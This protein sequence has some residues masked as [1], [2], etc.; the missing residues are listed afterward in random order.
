MTELLV[1]TFVKNHKDVENS[2]VRTSYGILASIVGIICNLILFG[3]KITVG[4]IMNSI[5]VMADA[6]NNLSDAA[7]SIISF[8]GVKLAERP[9]DKEHPFGHGRFEYIAALAVSFLILQ[10]GFSLFQSSFSKVLHPEDIKFNIVSVVILCVSVVI[11]IWLMFF[12]RKLGKRIKSSV[13]LATAADSLGDVTVTTATIISA[14]IAGITGLKIDGYVGLIVSIFV[15]LAGFRIA[16]ETL[17]PL[18]GQAVERE[19]YQRITNMVESYEGIVGSHDLIIHNYG[20]THHMATIHAEVPNNLNF[21]IAHETIDQI[22]RDVLE[23]LDIFLVIHMDPIEVN[24]AAVMEKKE[25]VT[26]IIQA[27]EKKA[28]LHDFRV[29]NGEHQINL[30]FDLVVPHS[31]S[32]D[33]EQRLLSRIIEEIRKNDTRY[34]CIITIE[35]SFIAEE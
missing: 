23:K 2:T 3:I 27:L 13:M 30:I 25:M 6:F 7:S 26:S 4:L 29:V 20:P 19:M 18:L 14:I 15:M 24:D 5:S 16:K 22:E 21:E 28:T 11:K 1:K 32:K 12:N 31:Y 10:V 17:E 35:N 33:E 9:A 34:Q 8:I